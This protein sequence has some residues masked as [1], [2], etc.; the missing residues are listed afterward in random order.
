ML[1]TLPGMLITAGIWLTDNIGA[2]LSTSGLESHF[3]KRH[4]TS[5]HYTAWNKAK[6]E[7]FLSSLY[8]VTELFILP[9][10]MC[11]FFPSSIY[12]MK[13]CRHGSMLRWTLTFETF[14]VQHLSRH[15]ML[16]LNAAC[17]NCH[18]NYHPSKWSLA[19]MCFQN[20]LRNEY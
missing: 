16:I 6:L 14:F 7:S 1:S 15:L 18:S 20:F 3:L 5:Y 11:S 12:T 8:L 2:G 13:G 4:S 17:Y 9:L 19:N 10:D